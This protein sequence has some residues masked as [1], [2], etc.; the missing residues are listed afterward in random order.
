MF[1]LQLHQYQYYSTGLLSNYD[2]FPEQ[3]KAILGPKKKIS[4]D[5]KKMERKIKGNFN[6]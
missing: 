4:K 5:Q 3:Q 2:H 6:M 1:V